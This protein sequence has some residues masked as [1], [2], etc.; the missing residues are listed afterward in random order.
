MAQTGI[1]E[2]AAYKKTH[3]DSIL[4]R[5]YLTRIFRPWHLYQKKKKAKNKRCD[6]ADSKTEFY[7]EYK[8]G[9]T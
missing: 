9:C 6:Y 5:T 8:T 4:R 7:I 1:E 2:D 3:S